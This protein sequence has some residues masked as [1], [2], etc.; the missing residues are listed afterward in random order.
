MLGLTL[1]LFQSFAQRLQGCAKCTCQG[2]AVMMRGQSEVSASRQGVTQPGRPGMR[3]NLGKTFLCVSEPGSPRCEVQGGFQKPQQPSRTALSSLLTPPATS[4]S[5]AALVLLSV[6]TGNSAEQSFSSQI[7]KSRVFH[8]HWCVRGSVTE[9]PTPHSTPS[10]P[11]AMKVSPGPHLS[12]QKSQFQLR[13]SLSVLSGV[14][15]A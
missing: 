15:G 2:E 14:S 5:R 3:V 8:P 4:S 9:L 10:Q 12:Y 7:H 6:R 1:P 11:R 13:A